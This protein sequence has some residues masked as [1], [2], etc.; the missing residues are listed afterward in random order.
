M[1]HA[2]VSRIFAAALAALSVFSALPARAVVAP[3]TPPQPL[4]F[5]GFS[6]PNLEWIRNVPIDGEVDYTV[7]TFRIG[8]FLYY[9]SVERFSIIDISKPLEPKLVS[10]IE[11]PGPGPWPESVGYRTEIGRSATNGK[12][13]IIPGGHRDY[14]TTD[15]PRALYVFDISDKAN[16]KKL[17]ELIVDETPWGM[18]CILDCK[19]VYDRSGQV[20]DLRDPRR[21]RRTRANWRQGLESNNY[22]ISGGPTAVSELREVAPGIVLTGSIPM[23]LLDARENPLHPRLLARSD[24][25]PLSWGDVAWP[26]FGEGQI[27]LS[28]DPISNLPFCDGSGATRGADLEGGFTTWDA[29]RWRTLA[30]MTPL[31]RYKPKNG[32]YADGDPPISADPWQAGCTVGRF[33][34][35]SRFQANGLVAA[36]AMSHGLKLLRVDDRGK[37]D[38]A[39]WFLPYGYGF[40]GTALFVGDRIVYAIDYSRGIDV[41]R[42]KGKV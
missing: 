37:I 23:Y 15:D 41:L 30:T 27:V 12:I 5:G 11:R 19:W 36:A 6:S 10:Q 39:A 40:T 3:R 22:V 7:V 1:Q 32:V 18:F 13:A 28:S 8:D 35:H 26:D 31:H 42:Y 24:G 29:S 38:V 14:F 2:Y 33:D 9:D 16:P 25:T 20:F 21:P 4:P 17:S 34:V